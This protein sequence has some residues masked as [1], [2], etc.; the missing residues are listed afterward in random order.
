MLTN[1]PLN[2]TKDPDHPVVLDLEVQDAQ[3]DVVR[4]VLGAGLGAGTNTVEETGAR[5]P[6]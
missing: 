5:V 1:P 2:S 6:P 4:T 3:V